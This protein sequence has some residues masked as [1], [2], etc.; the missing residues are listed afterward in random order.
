MVIIEDIKAN[1]IGFSIGRCLFRDLYQVGA[2]LFNQMHRPTSKYT[3]SSKG[4]ISSIV[5]KIANA[6]GRY[7]GAATDFTTNLD[8]NVKYPITPEPRA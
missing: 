8:C 7:Y 1:G 6:C 5:W 4:P 3:Y 2:Q